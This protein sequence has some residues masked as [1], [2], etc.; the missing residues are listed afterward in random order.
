MIKAYKLYTGDDGH[1][2]IQT[3]TLAEGAFNQASAI[4]FQESPPHSFYDWHNAPADQYVITLSG[5]LEFE[6]MPGETFVLKPGEILIAMDTTGTA[7]KWKLIDESPWIRVYVPFDR[8][9]PIPF[10]AD[11]IA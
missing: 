1:S 9:Q 3:G 2:H 4:R 7:H 8:S 5:T 10:I 11:E 6:T